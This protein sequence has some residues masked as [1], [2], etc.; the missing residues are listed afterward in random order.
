MFR[1]KTIDRDYVRY[2]QKRYEEPQARK[3]ASPGIA[4]KTR[5]DIDERCH[6]KHGAQDLRIKNGSGYRYLALHV[7]TERRYE[8]PEIYA[9]RLE[10]REE[11]RQEAEFRHQERRRLVRK[12]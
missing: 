8:K 5:D 3:E 4:V 12:I 11:T 2:R 7:Q 1:D 6:Y 9:Y 10:R